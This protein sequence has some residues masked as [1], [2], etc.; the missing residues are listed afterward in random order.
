[1]EILDNYVVK[2]QGVTYFVNGYIAENEDETMGEIDLEKVEAEDPNN[3]ESFITISDPMVLN[4]VK[5]LIRIDFSDKF[6][7][8]E[9]EQYNRMLDKYWNER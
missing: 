7:C 1:M 5:E 8:I 6:R 9:S 2:A 3:D 4:V